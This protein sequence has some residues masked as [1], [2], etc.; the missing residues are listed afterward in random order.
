MPE[1]SASSCCLCQGLAT[2][3]DLPGFRLFII[4]TFGA[5][6]KKIHRQTSVVGQMYTH[7]ATVIFIISILL[8]WLL[9][10]VAVVVVIAGVERL[11]G[12]VDEAAAATNGA[13]SQ[14]GHWR[15][16]CGSKTCSLERKQV[17]SVNVWALSA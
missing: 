8:M 5:E 2:F 10:S 17:L 13:Q 6:E 1:G 12:L 4:S 7:Y 14:L 3:F 11:L 15:E 9:L 16:Q